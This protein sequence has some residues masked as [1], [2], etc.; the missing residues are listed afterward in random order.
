MA[1]LDGLP[2]ELYAAILEQLDGVYE[3]RQQAIVSLIRAIPRSPVPDDLLFERVHLTK[4]RQTYDLYR[5]LRKNPNDADRVRVFTYKCWSANAD[6][7]VNLL[8]LLFQV[9]E[10][11][12]FFGPDFAPDHLEEIFKKPRDK[13]TML[14]LRFRP[15]V[16]KATYY[17]FLKGAYFDSTIES[18]SRWPRA[19]LS[20]I[21]L[22]QDPLDPTIA[23]TGSFAQPLVFF[24]LD[25]IGSLSASPYISTVAAFRFRVPARHI[26]RHIAETQQSVPSAELLDISTTTINEKELERLLSRLYRL[27]HLIMDGCP[28]ISQRADALEAEGAEELR[29]WASLGMVLATSGSITL[30]KAREQRFKM[31]LQTQAPPP[32]PEPTAEESTARQKKGGRRGLATATISLRKSPPKTTVPLPTAGPSATLPD[33][34]PLPE[35]IYVIPPLPMIKTLAVTA[36]MVSPDRPDFDANRAKVLQEF[37]R[38]WAQGMQKILGRRRMLRGTWTRKAAIYKVIP[39]EALSVDDDR[40]N[41]VMYELEQVRSF[42]DFDM[43]P[44][45]A[46]VLCLVGPGKSKNHPEGC[47]HR[48]AWDWYQDEL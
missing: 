9:R 17:Q 7:L 31:W 34:E 22:I 24:R 43:T 26:A 20:T 27:K 40:A 44:P 42:D 11:T 33:D 36:P 47:P 29:Q 37:E 1:R 28:I 4:P 6:H 3:E 30:S 46:P 2:L 41:D 12:L 18:I 39:G 15:Y 5:R 21:S 48:L 23:P 14:N 19:C 25:P 8:N 16:Q 10:M 35:K 45:P 38:G 13:L 32:P